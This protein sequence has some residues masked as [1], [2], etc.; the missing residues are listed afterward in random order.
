MIG[1]LSILQEEQRKLIDQVTDK[2][3]KVKELSKVVQ[4]FGV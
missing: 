1:K 3:K 4:N 2:D